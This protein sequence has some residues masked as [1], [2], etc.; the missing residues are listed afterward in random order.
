MKDFFNFMKKGLGIT[1]L[2]QNKPRTLQEYIAYRN[3][4]FLRAQARTEKFQDGKNNYYW[5]R[6]LDIDNQ[7]P[8]FKGLGGVFLKDEKVSKSRYK[9]A[10]GKK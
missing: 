2:W 8:E 4:I 7:Y 10:R 5:L 1:N 9:N 6:L 3:E